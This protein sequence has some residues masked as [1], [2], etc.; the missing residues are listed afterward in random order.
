MPS[1]QYSP[2]ISGVSPFDVDFVIPRVGVDIP[3]GIDPFLLYKS[4]DLQLASLHNLLIG[5][6]S[7][8]VDAVRQNEID[9]ARYLFDFP[10][11][12]AIGLGYTESGKRGSGVGPLLSQLII[13]TLMD[14]PSL[15]S[16]GVR[17]IE[18][19]QILS[20]GIG[21]D[22]ISDITANVLKHFLIEYT[23][24]QCGL[25][26]I[27]ITSGVPIAHVL[28][29]GSLSW[30]DGYFDLPCSP[31]NGE[32]ILLVPRRIVRALP[33]INYD[34]Y[35]RTEFSAYLRAKKL[36]KGGM[37][38]ALQVTASDKRTV[39]A[40]SRA[41]IERV[42]RYVRRKEE[43]GADAQ[44]S[45]SYLDSQQ[46]PAEA[47][48]LRQALSALPP[49]R[50]SASDYQRLVL[51]ILNYLFSPEL[52]DGQTEVRTYEGTER[53]DIIFTN[54]SDMPFWDYLRNEHGGIILMFETKNEDALQTSDLN[55]TATYLG[56]RVGRIGFIVTRH[57]AGEPQQKK[58]YS[59]Y[60]DSQPRKI[61]LVLRDADLKNMLDMKEKGKAPTRYVQNV[62]RAFRTSVQ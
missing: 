7:A 14:A 46:G 13:Q 27:P 38:A 30:R 52:I 40:V 8:G 2:L 32:P 34:D 31:L 16:R 51:E 45:V 54:D 18:E 39:V 3:L 21:P 44:P 11:V 17:H 29:P 62:Y 28:D 5:V 47:D 53:R 15:V 26:K 12:A 6:F 25:W 60:N 20:L 55:Q 1:N 36:R 41:E 59:I 23:Q 49:G 57:A 35:F 42:D 10:E 48:R 50:K 9:K 4:R 22:R 19:M 24:K 61:I 56:D 37:G 33:W 58:L 43:A